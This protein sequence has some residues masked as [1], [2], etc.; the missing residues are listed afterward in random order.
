[1][2][3]AYPFRPFFLLTALYAAVDVLA[4]V[5][6]LFGG[7]SLELG[8]SPVRWHAHE[9]LFAFLPAAFSGFLL[10]ALTNWTGAPPLRGRGLLALVLLWLAGRVAMWSAA[11]LPGWSVAAVDLAYLPV[12][13]VYL[14][15]TLVRYG[16]RRN[17]FLAGVVGLFAL[18]N[19]L[20]HLNTLGLIDGVAFG[21]GLALD[22]ITLLMVVIA[23][24][25]TPAFT[26]NW[27]RIHGGDP[28][29]VQ[30]LPGLDRA[31]I[32]FTAAMLP[33]DLL[34]DL[35]LAGAL[36]ALVACALN[37]ARLVLWSGWHARREP[38][39]WILH[40]GYLWIVAAL[41]FKG[42]IPFA[43]GIT[44]PV[45]VHA[46]GAG[47]A[48]TLIMGVMTRVSLGHTGRALSL[49]RFGVLMYLAVLTAGVLRVL[50][51]L[52]VIA[53]PLGVTAG[54]V[55]WATAFALFAAV[56]W[57]ILSRPRVDGRPG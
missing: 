24:R 21:Q 56:Y 32:A 38:L 49:P 50:A 46:I 57:P 37:G 11:W 33:F 45:W 13:A 54:A 20:F 22:L 19:L 55:A 18:A 27:L 52:G 4:W 9:M 44:A 12:L 26:A 41:L 5:G 25:I 16:N 31:A 47:A 39:L 35:P 48:G 7:W 30:S 2:L 53:Y 36:T 51:A 8:A 28:T 6:Y 17:L 23:G 43:G 10:T 14:G 34:T 15:R 1:M 40:L 29:V 42:L 3:L